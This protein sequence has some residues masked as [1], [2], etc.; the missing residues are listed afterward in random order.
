[1]KNQMAL[2]TLP[3]LMQCKIDQLMQWSIVDEEKCLSQ[4]AQLVQSVEDKEEKPYAAFPNLE[5][6]LIRDQLP[7]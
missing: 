1:M 5:S 6:I 2:Q 4:T 3:H 7:A